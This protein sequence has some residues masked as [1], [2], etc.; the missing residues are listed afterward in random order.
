MESI[1]I[2][3]K[4][5]AGK[6]GDSKGVSNQR[7]LNLSPEL[8]KKIA[9]IAPEDIKKASS[10]SDGLSLS[11]K[12]LTTQTHSAITDKVSDEKARLEAPLQPKGS[13]CD[14]VFYH[15][16]GAPMGFLDTREEVKDAELKA[17]IGLTEAVKGTGVKVPQ[18]IDDQAKPGPIVEK[19][20][21]GKIERARGFW[22]QCIPNMVNFKP[23]AAGNAM[24]AGQVMPKSNP[25]VLYQ[26]FLKE[27]KLDQA[28]NLKDGIRAVMENTDKICPLVGEV[29]LGIDKVSGDVFLFDV[30][31]TSG[32][33]AEGQADRIK[34]GLTNLYNL[35]K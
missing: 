15:E 31:P 16:E 17:Y 33:T 28:K 19:K 5:I 20:K 14:K 8:G 24:L 10:K 30:S 3:K 13:G 32:N 1:N 12:K 27:G 25:A 9:K 2:P 4:N 7:S 21:G 11:G 29:T 23:I 6:I 34:G 18:V 35:M 26:K 22:I